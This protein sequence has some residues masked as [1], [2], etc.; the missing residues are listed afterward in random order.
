MLGGMDAIIISEYADVTMAAATGKLDH[1]AETAR[2]RLALLIAL[3][4]FPRSL[5]RDTPAAFAQDIK[6]TRLALEGIRNG[7]FD[8][9]EPW[10][11][12]AYVVA[13]SHCEGPDHLERMEQLVPIV[14]AIGARLPEPIAQM[15]ARFRMQHGRVQGIIARFGRHPHRNAVL[16]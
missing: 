4:Q 5:W 16:G 1:L 14:D 3:G 10:E 12:A 13:I 2:G 8:E 11:Q 7:H 6:S 9:L 15:A